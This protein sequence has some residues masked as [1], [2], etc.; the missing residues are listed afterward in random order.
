M[1]SADRHGGALYHSTAE[2]GRSDIY[3]HM[4]CCC[5]GAEKMELME[6]TFLVQFVIRPHDGTA[7]WGKLQTMLLWYRYLLGWCQVGEI[8]IALSSRS[9]LDRF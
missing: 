5:G 8:N 9:L 3:A 6:L 7:E 2:R 1:N 4:Q